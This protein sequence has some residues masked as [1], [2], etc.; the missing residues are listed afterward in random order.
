MTEITKIRTKKKISLLE[1][2][3]ITSMA[4]PTAEDKRKFALMTPQERKALWDEGIT[5]AMSQTPNEVR[6]EDIRTRALK[7]LGVHG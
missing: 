2:H 4:A 7:R 6:M 5:H 3:G 1:K